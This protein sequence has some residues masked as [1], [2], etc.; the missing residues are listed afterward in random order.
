MIYKSRC[1]ESSTTLTD[2]RE[3]ISE[4]KLSLINAFSFHSLKILKVASTS[5]S[6]VK[7]G[8]SCVLFQEG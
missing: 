3:I 5:T 4:S 8:F 7:G 6:V 1:F 2:Q